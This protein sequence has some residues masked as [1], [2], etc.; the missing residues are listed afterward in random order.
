MR[1]TPSPQPSQAGAASSFFIL[2]KPSAHSPLAA[3][4]V[5]HR[6]EAEERKS[7]SRPM[8]Q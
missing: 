8:L 7:L 5:W 6:E 4:Q 1:R 3:P 2:P